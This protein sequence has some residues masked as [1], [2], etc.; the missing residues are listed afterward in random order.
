MT[1]CRLQLCKRF[2]NVG[3]NLLRIVT[4]SPFLDPAGM[5]GFLLFDITRRDVEVQMSR[6]EKQSMICVMLSPRHWL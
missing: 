4:L 1:D 6:T 2:F 5:L 3:K